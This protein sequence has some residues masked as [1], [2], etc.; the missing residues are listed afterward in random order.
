[1]PKDTNY[2]I[3]LIEGLKLSPNR[4]VVF[5]Q[6]SDGSLNGIKVFKSLQES[7][8]KKSVRDL[9]HRFDAWIDGLHNKK[10]FHGWDDPNYR[11][12][13]VFKWTDRNVMQRL[14][15]FLEN[16]QPRLRPRFQ[17][18]VLHTNDSKTQFNT[19]TSHLKLSEALKVDPKVSQAIVKAFPDVKGN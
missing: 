2:S 19:E 18:C 12:S 15:G 8:Q 7:G 5:L 1:M 16:P 4:G 14:Y 17:V 11:N 6:A 3:V 10:M 13:F 9:Q